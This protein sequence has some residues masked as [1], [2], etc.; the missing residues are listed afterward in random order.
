M[1]D[2]QLTKL[3]RKKIIIG[4]DEVGRGSWAG[5]LVVGAVMLDVGAPIAGLKD[6]K[7]ILKPLREQLAKQVISDAKKYALGWVWPIEIDELGLTA[8]T[9]L[10]IERAIQHM[11]AYDYVVIDGSI[12][13]L[14]DNQKAISLV[15]ADDRVTAVSAASI[16][17]KVS[18]DNYMAEQAAKYP[19][20]GFDMHV[21]YGTA[22]HKN[23]LINHG[24]TPLHRLSFRP[25]QQLLAEY[26]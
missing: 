4:V 13:F 18:R 20:Y 8:A 3:L 26:K 7:Q 23:A 21:G 11:P 24:I 25:I 14:P 19:E 6:S 22:R 15:K 9:T 12:N 5:P 17:A 2:T 1:N 16:L 10:A